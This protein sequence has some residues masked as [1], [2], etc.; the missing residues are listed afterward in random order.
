MTK[1]IKFIKDSESGK[2]D[3][4]A[5]VN[6]HTAKVYTEGGYAAYID[7]DIKQEKLILK[8]YK[9][10]PLLKKCKL[11][12]IRALSP[13]AKEK[14]GE[15]FEWVYKPRFEQIVLESVKNYEIIAFLDKDGQD[16]NVKAEDVKN[17]DYNKAYEEDN[18]E[19]I[20]DVS[21]NKKQVDENDKQVAK[22]NI[23]FCIKEFEKF[24]NLLMKNAPIGYSP[25]FFCC[26]P[27]DKNPILGIS[28]K[29]NSAKLS[30]EQAI[31]KIKLGYNIAISARADDKLIQFDIDNKNYLEQ[32]PKNTLTT[33]SRS[34][35]GGHCF[36]W[37][38]DK[39]AKIN[40]ATND[41][42]EIRSDDMYLIAPGSYVPY[43][44]NKLKD[45]EKFDKLTNEEKTDKYLGYYTIKDEFEPREL[46][47]SDFPQFFKDAIN[48]EHEQ[49]TEVLQKEERK[50]Y[51]Q[52]GKY[53]DLFNLKMKDIVGD[54]SKNI[55]HPLH[56][57][58]TGS[59]FSMSNDGS[60]CHCWRHMV[61]L[62]PV[63]Y[64]CVKAGYMSC[65]DAGTPH[66]GRG[67]S[68][69]RGDKKAYEVAYNEAVKLGLI[70]NNSIEVDVSLTNNNLNKA[71]A[72][73][74]DSRHL[75]Q[76][77]IKIQ[78]LYYARKNQLYLY[79]KESYCWELKDETD[80]LNAISKHS[81]A[82]TISSKSKNEILE[83]LKQ[84]GRMNKPMDA[85]STWV[86]FQNKIYDIETDEIF[87]AS[88]KYFIMN[89]LPWKV[90]KCEETP[91][92]DNLIKS[93][94]R[95]EDVPLIYEFI[96]F[97]MIP[98][99]FIHSF[100]FLYAPPGTGKSTFLR[101]LVRLL[102][103]SNCIST[104]IERI[105]NSSRFETFNWC[106]KLL[107]AL[108]EVSDIDDLKNSSLINSATGED[109]ITAEVKG[110]ESFQFTNYGKFVYATNKLLK[111]DAQDGFGRRVRTIKFVNRFE[112][113]KDV[114]DDIPEIE[115]ENL[116]KKCLRIA[117]E[118]WKKRQFTGDVSISQRMQNYQEL[119]KTIL[120]KFIDKYC[121][122]TDFNTS[123][124]FDE[125]YSNFIRI[126]QVQESKVSI[127]RQLKKLGYEPKHMNWQEEQY[128]SIGH[129]VTKWISGTKISG[130][131]LKQ[132]SLIE[133]SKN[134]LENNQLT[135]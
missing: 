130:I 53:D 2:K 30:K 28:W 81:Y 114:L 113:E 74:T 96:A 83:A 45:K 102:G 57:S 121:D 63:Q 110:G 49:E 14:Y 25:W 118:L 72:V 9:P 22:R 1:T 88:E 54:I 124:S 135:L 12:K 62:N 93:W 119:S 40:F 44:L 103:K 120:E 111:V 52:G 134:K 87:D 48:K 71:I 129:V 115:F 6:E 69:I 116:A 98:K 20:E 60:I 94:V 76:Q 132:E 123:I 7:E 38:K 17:F 90:G 10:H 56:D 15:I 108:S 59:N 35:T 8:K 34:R 11:I 106:N 95:G 109:L 5:F 13:K 100:F 79:N 64:L 82:N 89:P 55:A 92:I 128:D 75:A 43:N 51:P 99:Y 86:Q 58:D 4:I 16:L 39:T 31:E 19:K 85:K 23:I 133:V 41:D 131:K 46:S 125:F 101:L 24:Y 29:S 68:K 37:D 107:I 105:N 70:K 97:T 33:M 42:G 65:N 3:E 47:Y 84:E 78:P 67:I 104:T 21:E 66:K 117:G 126:Q 18:K 77:F 80:I 61:S 91:N 26:E 112:K 32:L 36:G 122:L 27:N 73:F 127:S 50:T